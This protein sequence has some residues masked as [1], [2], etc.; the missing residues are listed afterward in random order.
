MDVIMYLGRGEK[1]K[2][3]VRLDN[4]NA[5]RYYIADDQNLR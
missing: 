4:N 5:V 1:E 2:K 3:D